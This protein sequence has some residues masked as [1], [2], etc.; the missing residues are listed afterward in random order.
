MRERIFL[1]LLAVLLIP[2]LMFPEGHSATDDRVFFTMYAKPNM[3]FILDQS[4]S[5]GNCDVY[6]GNWSAYNDFRTYTTSDGW[7][8]FT[9]S[10]CRRRWI[11]GQRVYYA[12]RL[13]AAKRTLIE[14]I[15]DFRNELNIGFMDFHQTAYSRYKSI[16]GKIIYPIKDVSDPEN[17]SD[18]NV[19]QCTQWRHAMMNSVYDIDPYGYTPLAETLDTAARYFSQGLTGNKCSNG[20]CPSPITAWCQKNFVILMT[21]GYP[22]SDNFQCY[23]GSRSG[24]EYWAFIPNLQ[25]NCN[26]YYDL[27]GDNNTNDVKTWG[28]HLLDD[29]AW[30]IYNHDLRDDM[31]GDQN[32]TTYTI[33]F[34][35]GDSQLLQHA[36]QVGG[37]QYYDAQNY[38]Q[39][40]DSI[41]SAVHYIL[42]TTPSFAPIS[43]PKTV[44]IGENYGFISWFKPKEDER[45][46]EGHLDAFELNEQGEFETDSEGNPTNSVWDA[47]LVLTNFLKSK[48]LDSKSVR[49]ALLSK[50]F[51]YVYTRTLPL[52]SIQV[53]QGANTIREFYQI[54]SPY[55]SLSNIDAINSALLGCT[56]TPNGSNLEVNCDTGGTWWAHGDVFHSNVVMVGSPFAFLKY[57]PLYG[58]K[59]EEFYNQ[60]KDRN[61]LIYYGANDGA[62]HVVTVKDWDNNGTSYQAGMIVRE[63]VP[64][65][66]LPTLTSTAINN[67]WDYSVD[68][69]ITA[70]DIRVND[71]SK[72]F[73]ERDFFTLLT[74]GLRQG[75][76]RYYGID[77]TDPA[78]DYGTSS[79]GQN[80]YGKVLWEFPNVPPVDGIDCITFWNNAG[81][82][83]PGQPGPPYFE[84]ICLPSP[85]QHEWVGGYW[86]PFMGE[87]WGRPKVGLVRYDISGS[88]D[89]IYAVFVTGGYPVDH[90]PNEW[91]NIDEGAGL[92]IL[93]ASSGEVIKA[94][95]RNEPTITTHQGNRT[96]YLNPPSDQYEVVDGLHSLVGT[97]TAVDLNGDGIIDTIYVGDIK[98]NIWKVDISSTDK[99]DWEMGKLA[100]LGGDQNI[101]QKV[102]VALDSCG[103]RW[104]FA[105]TGR[106]DEPKNNDATWHMV[107]IIDVSGIPSQPITMDDLQDISSIL[108]D[109]EDIFSEENNPSTVTLSSSAAGWK[110]EFPDT[111]EKLFEDPF[112]FGDLYFTTYSPAGIG[113]ICSA[114]GAMHAYR[115]TVPGC[116]GD[117]SA[118]RMG[119]RVGGGGVAALGSYEIYVTDSTPGSKKIIKQK[120]LSL[121]NIF[122]PVYWRVLHEEE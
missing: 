35:S 61:P 76:K 108:E 17:C 3:L 8:T 68:G 11:S 51:T 44:T 14:L 120:S 58:S 49:D 115:I 32:L 46:W 119:G 79:P 98:G 92:F 97:P 67:S 60:W 39:L 102:A 87:T 70:L 27:D 25:G 40:V 15:D 86:L 95:V 81:G 65:N 114:G 112:V 55:N 90:E 41:R 33:K 13:E 19:N 74:F 26:S 16:G 103:R 94:F 4:G 30:W 10:Y 72:P 50:V 59:Y 52:S 77:V 64:T 37:G 21:D 2:N 7:K 5:M 66:T 57:L 47:G 20:P 69:Y 12:T 38:A 110:L 75:G 83:Q 121:S 71:R 42:Q 96:I 107:G 116:G 56:L 93:N 24:C 43:A 85:Y 63:F 117:I 23:C 100:E 101:F 122:G 104:V 80:S 78:A 62:L 9:F 105:G 84:E 53:A 29:V 18:S 45:I 34:R 31:D 111:G 89:K 22:T 99:D 48:N 36:A 73:N 113:D 6:I 82:P 54:P 109:V 91:N 1:V 28:S 118:V 106:R 88:V